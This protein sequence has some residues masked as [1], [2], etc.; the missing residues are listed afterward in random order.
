MSTRR[1]GLMAIDGDQLN[2]F[3]GR[4][5][6]DFGAVL[7]APL[8]ILGDRLGLYRALSGAG[9]L[10]PA[11]LAKKTGLDERY[12]TEWLCANAA[13]G[14]VDHDAA[15]GRFSMNEVQ[16]FTLADP[17]SPAYI[18][19]AFLL[20]SSVFHDQ[21]KLEEA[22]RTGRG[23]G[24]H[25]HHH[26]LFEGTEKF[27]RPS[28]AGNLVGSWIPALEGVEAKLKEGAKVAD[29]G[30]GHG[31]STILMAQAYP[32]STFFGFDYHPASIER[33]QMAAKAAGVSDRVTFAVASAKAFPARSYDLVAFF[34]C[35]HDM[36]DPVGAAAHVLTTLAPEGT[37]MIVE[38][39]AAD[40]VEQNLNPVGRIFYS[41]STMIC[42]PAS[43]SQEV[44][45]ALGAQ[46]GEA[47]LRDVV[48]SGGFKRFRRATETPF[49][50]I[51]EARA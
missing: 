38:P 22:F 49:N 37:W 7:H 24:W 50:M 6:T 40:R 14:Y 42:T 32:R 46:A 34:D 31:A 51:L 2:A 12:V 33:A 5:V 19:G 44:G 25:E 13:S 30:C 18:P 48:T 39:M 20:A 23:V 27:F 35:L 29:V 9:A 15:S 36:G 1:G 10:L 11:E 3:M 26:C 4:F 47:R 8:V 28:Y 41:A 43:R 21:S 17:Q 45:L 16:S